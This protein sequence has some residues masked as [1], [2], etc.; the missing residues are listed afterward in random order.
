ME[1]ED[2]REVRAFVLAAM[3]L[4]AG[5]VIGYFVFSCPPCQAPPEQEIC[6]FNASVEAPYYGLYNKSAEYTELEICDMKTNTTP[7]YYR[8]APFAV[9]GY[10]R[11]LGENGTFLSLFWQ[12]EEQP[13]EEIEE[14]AA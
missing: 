1:K 8:C 3:A 13:L 14:G 9:N 11:I 10:Y 4:L 6:T 5:F 7:A 12:V 2:E